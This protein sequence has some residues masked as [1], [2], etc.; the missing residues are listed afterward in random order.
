MMVECKTEYA[1]AQISSKKEIEMQS[2]VLRSIPFIYELLGSIAGIAVIVNNNRQVVYANETFFDTLGVE[3]FESFLGLRLG[4]IYGCIHSQNTTGG[5]GTS[6]YCRYCGAVN[7]IL[8]SQKTG[9]QIVKECRLSVKSD[10]NMECLDIS[11]KATPLVVLE[12]AFTVI[13]VFDIS[14]KKRKEVL[15]RMFY[16][17]VI[18]KAGGINSLI[19]F[20]KYN[21]SLDNNDLEELFDTL[22]ISSNELVEEIVAQRDLALAERNELILKPEVVDSE[23]LVQTIVNLFK[24]HEIGKDK[25]IEVVVPKDELVLVTD[26]IILSRVLGNLLKNALEASEPNQIVTLELRKNQS[27]EFIVKNMTYMPEE[28]EKQL[29]KRSFSTKGKGRGL[30]TYSVK[31]LTER[32]LKGAVHFNTDVNKG[33]QFHVLLPESI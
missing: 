5:C 20:I 17:D 13:S 31:L 6:K 10:E 4:N 24:K 1:P 28:V 21:S 30:G 7:V 22:Y 11:I 25:C 12:E 26:K 18:N 16:H 23:E 19:A 14:D 3:D 27:I 8:D 15:E 2:K 32:Y 9:K 33:T 29:F